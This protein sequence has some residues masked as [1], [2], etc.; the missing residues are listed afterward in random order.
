M[1]LPKPHEFPI[2]FSLMAIHSTIYCATMSFPGLASIK[3]R[4]LP[5][6]IAHWRTLLM[7]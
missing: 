5:A 7:S 1:F 2:E 3:S 4:D 6:L